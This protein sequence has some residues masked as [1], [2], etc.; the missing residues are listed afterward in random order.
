M[1]RTELMTLA[2]LGAV[3]LLVACGGQTPAPSPAFKIDHFRIY[4][5]D[6]LEVDLLVALEGQ[7]D[8]SKVKTRLLKVTHFANPTRKVHGG[9]QEGVKD[10]NA[11]L[12]GYALEQEATE[13]RRTVR[14]RNQFGQHSVDLREPRFLL[15]PTQKT[16]DP[17]SAFPERLDH[18]KC[19]EVIRV[20]VAPTLPMVL[21][22]HQFGSE[23]DVPLEGPRLFCLP[24]E[25]VRPD[26]HEQPIQN[27]RDHL[28]L[29]STPPKPV[30]RPI[31]T[32][33]QFGER[34]LKVVRTALLAVPSEKQAVAAH[35][36]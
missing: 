4:E 18:Y 9:A 3:L 5:V 11:H 22:G 10:T 25:K 6:P 20:N 34:Q 17:N 13:P 19:Y 12:T 35:P 26:A 21:L 27:A 28:A 2:A 31:E 14:F 24:V 36:D 33:D 7:F 1:K 29:Y 15:V 16:S 30:E 8:A 23:P 32:R